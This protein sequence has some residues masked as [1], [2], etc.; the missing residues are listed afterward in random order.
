VSY[1]ADCYCSR[2]TNTYKLLCTQRC[3]YV[4]QLARLTSA[5]HGPLGYSHR[6]T[7]YSDLISLIYAITHKSKFLK[8]GLPTGYLVAYSPKSAFADQNADSIANALTKAYERAG[9]RL[10]ITRRSSVEKTSKCS[11]HRT[12]TS[13]DFCFLTVAVVWPTYRWFEQQCFLKKSVAVF[14]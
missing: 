2:S 3:V 6:P 1:Y 5:S 8:I 9:I 13:C 14:L 7:F 4:V 12:L 11:P 10:V